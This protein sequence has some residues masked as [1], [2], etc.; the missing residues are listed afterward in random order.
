MVTTVLL[1]FSGN[2][3]G[4]FRT[5]VFSEAAL[6][7]RQALLLLHQFASRLALAK[8]SFHEINTLA[9]GRASL[10]RSY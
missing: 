3:L 1:F 2:V 6:V 9:A 4:H 10:S 8:K 7:I 5:D